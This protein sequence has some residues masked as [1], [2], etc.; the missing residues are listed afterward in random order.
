ML[1]F[2]PTAHM[3]ETM[4]TVDSKGEGCQLVTY[5]LLGD[6]SKTVR[7]RGVGAGK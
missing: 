4:Q 6:R 1:R 3:I 2:P 5:T 7:L